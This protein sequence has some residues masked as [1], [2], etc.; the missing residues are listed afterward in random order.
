MRITEHEAILQLKDITQVFQAE[1]REEVDQKFYNHLT[2]DEIREN[3]QEFNCLIGEIKQILREVEVNNDVTVTLSQEEEAVLDKI[4]AEI[5][6]WYWQADKQALAKDPCV[7]DAMI[8]LFIRTI[9]KYK[10][11]SEDN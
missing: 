2:L 4:K 10:A 11:E 5:K 7:V 1:D 6:G 8:D 3:L 9:D